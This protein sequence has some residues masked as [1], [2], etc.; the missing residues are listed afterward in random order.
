MMPPELHDL[1]PDELTEL[2]GSMGEPP[3]RGRQVAHGLFRRGVEAVNELSDL[4]LALRSRLE[5]EHGL[6]SLKEVG[7]Q[8]AP[9][10]TIKHLFELGDGQRIESVAIAM[11]DDRR[12]FC[13]SSQ[14]G[15]RMACVFCATARM[16]RR[17]QLRPGEIVAQVIKLT[18]LHPTRRQANLVFMGMGEPLD[19]FENLARAL[20]ILSHPEAL[21]IGAR[22]IT[23]S[24]SGPLEGMRRLRELQRPYG[25]ALSLTSAEEGDRARLMPV[26][27][28]DSMEEVL[29]LAAEHGRRTARKVTLECV[30]IA[31]ENDDARSAQ[32]LVR[33]AQRGPFKVNLIPLNEIEGYEGKRP[34]Q[35]NV[36]RFAD[37]L[38]RAGIV[39]TVRESAGREV[40]AACGQLV[41]KSPRAHRS[42]VH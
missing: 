30:L 5:Q 32:Q 37:R 36:K 1:N 27:G 35:E 24:T 10:G 26:A 39:C 14:V 33:V 25:L 2:L 19:N 15:C 6:T 38:W 13:L 23:I 16:G 41:Q 12:T 21:G 3:Y 9:D 42:R 40:T 17:K 8:P 11:G 18:R 7:R 34:S 31:G 22:H 4:P 28:S 20:A 29:G